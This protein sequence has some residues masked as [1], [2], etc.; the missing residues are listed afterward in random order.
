L[1]AE[2]PV[3]ALIRYL[4]GAVGEIRLVIHSVPVDAEHVT[5]DALVAVCGE[6]LDPNLVEPPLS[7]MDGMPCEKCFK[8]AITAGPAGEPLPAPPAESS[9]PSSAGH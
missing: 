2:E 8:I 5:R 6:R 9:S 7:T 4:P 1:P 3:L